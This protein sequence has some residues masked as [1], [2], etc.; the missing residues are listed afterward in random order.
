HVDS[1]DHMESNMG[2]GWITAEDVAKAKEIIA[3]VSAEAAAN[4]KEQMINNIAMGMLNKF[5]K[6]NCLMSQAYIDDSKINVTQYLE[7]V[8]KGLTVTGFKRFTLRAE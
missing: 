2:K 1:E 4:L 3:T 6:E 5:F 7:S 8:E